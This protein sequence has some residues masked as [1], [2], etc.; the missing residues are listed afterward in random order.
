MWVLTNIVLVVCEVWVDYDPMYE[1]GLLPALPA[2]VP[3]PEHRP[4]DPAAQGPHQL[5][6]D[7]SIYVE[8]SQDLSLL[9][10]SSLF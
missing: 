7:K 1:H 10:L 6:G 4:P 3:V 2:P 5:A 9:F 8:W